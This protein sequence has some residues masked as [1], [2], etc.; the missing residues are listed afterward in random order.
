MERFDIAVIGT[1]PAGLEAAITAKV[2]NKNV[3]LIGSRGLS[4]K[5]EK[6]HAIKNYLGLPEVSGEEMQ[7]TFQKH[8][9]QMD[10]KITEDRVNTVY[11]MGDYFAIQGHGDMYEAET[12]ILSCG[13]SV[14]KPFPGE[15]ENLGR[16]VSY[17]AT[18]DAALY[19]GKTAVVVGYSK[20][21]EKEAEFLAEIA[22]KVYY[23]PMYKDE[24]SLSNGIDVIS[25]AKPLAIEKKDNRIILNLENDS[26]EADGIFLLRESVAPS[27]LVP[28]LSIEKNQVVVDRS[29]R[30]NIPGLFA[31]GDITGA[32]YQYIKAAGE[33]NVAALS[34]VNYLAQQK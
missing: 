28:G 5:V 21:E 22:D 2:R 19:K 24:I 17:C 15:L 16:G 11:A 10:V 29:L 4:P 1:G 13:M 20:E 12:V 9:D 34:A 23:L 6:A 30:T 8:L 26:I 7:S 33:G 27:Q 18:C 32:P 3:L 31:C 14:A 25:D